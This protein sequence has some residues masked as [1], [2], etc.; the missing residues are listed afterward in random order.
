[1]ESPQQK[2]KAV[3]WDMG[4]VLLRTENREPRTQ[5]ALEY[6]LTYEMLE[7]IV[8]GSRSA[9]QAA[10]G[11]IPVAEHWNSVQSLLQIADDQLR[12]FKVQFWAGDVVDHELVAW[13]D[14][15]R[16]RYKTGLLSNAWEDMREKAEKFYPFLHAFD[17]SVFSAE[18]N[19]AKP[20]AEFYQWML[21]KLQVVAE[22]AIF[23]DDMLDNVLAAK[24]FGIHGIRFLSREQTIKDIEAI[25]RGQYD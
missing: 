8:Y 2:I 3:I 19:M 21:D 6:G 15:L 5:L 18:I 9:T 7:S 4:G 23:V 1:M 11:V 20:D 25:L 14:H 12:E 16:P 13:I 17:V 24:Q 10:K 22:E